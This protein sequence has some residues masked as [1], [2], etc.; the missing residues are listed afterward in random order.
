MP[1]AKKLRIL[2]TGGGTGGHL[3]PAVAI[4]EEFKARFDRDNLQILFVGT[5]RGLEA[6]ILPRLGYDFRPIWIRGFQRGHTFKDMATNLLFPLRVLTSIVQSSLLLS[7][8]DPHIAIGT[9]GYTA[10]PP[11]YIAMKRKIPYFLHEQNVIPGVTTRLLQKN[12]RRVYTSFPIGQEVLT[13][14]VY[15][16]MPLRRALTIRNPK[17]AKA[18]F[19][20][21]FNART[22]LIFGGSQG[23]HGINLYLIEN[24]ENLLSHMC[25]QVIWQTGTLDFDTAK[26]RYSGKRNL[27]LTE[28]IHDM[29]NAY[30]A[31]DLIICRAG[32][33][34]LAELAFYGKPAVL[35]P[36]PTAAAD[37][38][39]LNA[40]SVAASGAAK[41]ILQQDLNPENFDKW[42][43]Q[44]INDPAVLE[45]M[46]TLMRKRAKPDA[47]RQIVDD[48]LTQIE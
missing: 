44:T 43:I 32:A 2:I 8:F 45:Q 40:Q 29:E 39:V 46:G 33:L 31:A 27:H 15:T 13:N 6:K 41:V 4:A 35:I 47:A 26:T 1:K 34:T 17:A 25:I 5:R 19:G 30:S 24:L 10:G 23:A 9:G 3:F 21:D 48:I 38:Q 16:G 7:H 14:S 18:S 42:I 22:I 36:L 37:H 20:L 11:L 28:F 12:A